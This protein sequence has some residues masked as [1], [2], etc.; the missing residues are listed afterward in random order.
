MK[1]TGGIENLLLHSF[2]NDE[3][4]RRQ[5]K[6]L[7]LRFPLWWLRDFR[8]SDAVS[9]LGIEVSAGGLQFLMKEHTPTQCSIAAEIRGRRMRANLLVVHTEPIVHDHEAWTRYRAKFIGL[10]ETDFEFIMSLTDC[11]LLGSTNNATGSTK[12]RASKF[13]F[14]SYDMLPLATQERIIARLVVLKRL[15]RPADISLANLAAHYGGIVTSGTSIYHRYLIRSR[16]PSA[17]THIVF[18]TDVLVSDDAKEILFR[19]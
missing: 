2:R 16:M 8:G 7:E 18:N 1:E 10:L 6:R 4:E 11:A 19:D 9:G 12:R 15:V 5:Y 17:G 3:S 14:E 13:N